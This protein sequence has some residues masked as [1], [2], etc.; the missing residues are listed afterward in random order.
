MISIMIS[1]MNLDGD[2]VPERMHLAGHA[3][4]FINQCGRDGEH[5]FEYAGIP[6][7]VYDS[8]LRGLSRSRNMAL[9]KAQGE[10]VWLL[11]DDV[12][13]SENCEKDI[14]CAFRENPDA[15]GILFNIISDTADRPQRQV[16]EK[17]SL[18]INNAM[19]YPTY[20]YV[21]RK[22]PIKEKGLRF[23]EAFGSGAPVSNGEDSIFTADCLR[24]GLRLIA[25]PV[26]IG[27]VKHADSAWFGGFDAKF[28]HD[29]GAIFRAIF[30]WKYPLYCA[31][32]LFR[33]PEWKNGAPFLRAYLDMLS[34]AR[35]YRS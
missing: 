25:V 27:R 14:E 13:L 7:K 22:S 35:G 30:G 18:G 15:D 21:Y 33:R 11:D 31:V 10:Y 2:T 5:S 26:C 3:A 12:V 34:G 9:G 1:T 23:N 29:K 17:H 20:R 8:S 4:S 32:M 16:S 19:A 6:Y 24:S 28:R